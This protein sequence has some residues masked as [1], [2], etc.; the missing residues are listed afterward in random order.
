MEAK[1]AMSEGTGRIEAFSDGVFAVAMTLLVIEI[2]VPA[3]TPE[4]NAGLR[5]ALWHNWPRYYAYL[6]SFGTV[7]LMWMMHHSIFK[8]YKRTTAPL[9]LLNGLLLL[10][11]VFLPYP[12]RT[13]SEFVLTPA[14]DTAI[15]FYVGFFFVISLAFNLLLRVSLYRRD[16]LHE[17]HHD[18]GLRQLYR[19]QLVGLALNGTAAAVS[20]FLPWAALALNFFTWIYW[21]T[22]VGR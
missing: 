5:T 19:K 4:T 14:R 20:F 22:R 12:T 21:A 8:F 1:P 16:K 13:L 15:Q 18:E 6:N 9:M 2:A 10:L 11:I 7:L 17:A 3:G